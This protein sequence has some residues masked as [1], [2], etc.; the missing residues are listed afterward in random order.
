MPSAARRIFFLAAC[1]LGAVTLAPTVSAQ[2]RLPQPWASPR[3]Q[4]TQRIG[5]TDV[6]VD[7]GRPAVKGREVWGGLVPW[8]EVWRCGANENTTIHFANDVQIEGQPLPA[9]TYGLHMI[10]TPD[11]WTVIFSR[12]STSWGSFSYDE[13]EDALRVEVKPESAP[14]QEWLTY[15]FDDL[16]ANGATLRLHWEQLAVPIRITVDTPKVVLDNARNNYLRGVNKFSWQ[17]WNNAARYCLQNKVNLDEALEWS[18]NSVA[19]QERFENLWLR[20]RLLDATGKTADA[21]TTRDRALTLGAEADINTAG[22]ELLQSGKAAD[23]LALFQRNA[24]RFPDSWNAWDSLAEANEKT[25]D[26]TKAIELYKKA[27]AMAPAD[28]Q[29][30][31]EGIIKGLEGS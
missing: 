16:S 28:Q 24:E 3:A 19:M 2:E 29:G 4:Y 13:K 1:S 18:A 22:Y 10:P 23:A 30:R 17:G 8:N 31:I 14:M 15:A 6:T 20:A 21:Q 9:G 27:L 11:R 7:A 25:G 26:K 12:N 5:I